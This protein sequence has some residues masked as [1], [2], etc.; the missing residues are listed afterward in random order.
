MEKT[1]LPWERSDEEEE[2]EK[3]REEEAMGL[4]AR[5]LCEAEAIGEARVLRFRRR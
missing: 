5:A 2:E 1:R 4:D 3:K